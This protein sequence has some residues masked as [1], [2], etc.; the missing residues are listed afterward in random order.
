EKMRFQGAGSSMINPSLYNSPK[1]AFENNGIKYKYFKGYRESELESNPILLNEALKA[2][3]DYKK[4][5]VFAGL[6]DYAESEG[7]DRDTMSLPINQLDL[8]NELIKQDKEIILVLFGGSVIE[9]PFYNNVKAILDMFL[10]GQNGGQATYELLYGVVN[11]SGRLS[12]TWPIT[13]E[14]V[15]FGKNFGKGA[16]EIYK[17]SIYVGYRYYLT[18]N[19][20]VRFPFGYGLS[21]SKFVYSGL[22]IKIENNKLSISLNVKNDSEVDG[23]EIVQAY[24]SSPKGKAFKALRELKGFI[25]VHLKANETKTVNVDIDLEELKFWAPKENRFVLEAGEYNIQIGKN[26]RD[27]MLEK[28]IE[29]E[30][31][32]ISSEFEKDVQKVY[33]N[34]KFDEITDELFEK[35]SGVKVPLS[36]PKKPITLETRFTDYKLTFMGKILYNSVLASAKKEMKE[37][38]KLP[39]GTER[40]N[41][42]KGATFLKRILDSNSIRT[43]SMSAGP[44][45]PYNFAEGFKDLA[46][47]HIIKGIKDFTTKIKAPSL[48]DDK[49]VK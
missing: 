39:E 6:T 22:N 28:S 36:L 13:Y 48:P 1:N 5:V 31:E 42:I 26:S 12:E 40:E 37:A 18:A 11:P 7:G 27:I 17:E 21:Y 32:E 29:I 35:M 10:P 23:D 8:I 43:L 46:N 47:G 33:E 41:K 4:V 16:N 45:L 25:K 24:V 14:D 20:E 44:S 15:P 3:K 2:A 30:G 34:L 38:L 19:K 49:E 9:L